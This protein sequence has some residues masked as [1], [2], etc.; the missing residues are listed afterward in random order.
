[1]TDGGYRPSGPAGRL[2]RFA[3]E[4]HPPAIYLPLSLLWSLS[5]VSMLSAGR[6]FRA[7]DLLV[8]LVF[9]LVLLFL[10]AVDEVKD[11]EYDRI[12]NPGRPLV[13]GPSAGTTSGVLPAWP[14]PWPLAFRG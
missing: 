11:L 3:I 2:M 10:R 6:Q 1:M 13:R 5:M 4:A 8:S 9:F 14:L 12:H 7:T